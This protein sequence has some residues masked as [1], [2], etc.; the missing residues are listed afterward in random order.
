[1]K[2]DF[3]IYGRII[4]SILPSKTDIIQNYRSNSCQNVIGRISLRKSNKFCQ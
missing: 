3:R 4:L 1:M 2:P